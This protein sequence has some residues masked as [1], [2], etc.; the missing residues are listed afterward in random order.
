MKTDIIVVE[1]VEDGEE[2]GGRRGD[3]EVTIMRPKSRVSL[4]LGN[5]RGGEG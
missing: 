1:R 3:I 5:G 4:T 2:D